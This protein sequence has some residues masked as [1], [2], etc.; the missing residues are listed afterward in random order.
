MNPQSH[1]SNIQI[2]AFYQF[3]RWP[4]TQESEPTNILV[5]P[6]FMHMDYIKIQQSTKKTDNLNLWI[7]TSNIIMQAS[8]IRKR[9]TFIRWRNSHCTDSLA[10]MFGSHWLPSNL[11]MHL[12]FPLH[13]A[14][15]L[16][17][18]SAFNGQRFYLGK[19]QNGHLCHFHKR[20]PTPVLEDMF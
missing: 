17:C 2:Y 12:H 13:L 1:T 15:L 3:N 8:F 19:V 14:L 5:Q 4:P 11:G 9:L 18:R 20:C 10:R 16:F 6:L 7:H